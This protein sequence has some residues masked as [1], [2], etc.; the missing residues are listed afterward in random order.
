M[1]TDTFNM[2]FAT[3]GNY[4]LE[5]VMTNVPFLEDMDQHEHLAPRSF[6]EVDLFLMIGMAIGIPANVATFGILLSSGN[7]R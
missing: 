4:S 6:R 1:T 2:E 7:L 3:Q 5:D